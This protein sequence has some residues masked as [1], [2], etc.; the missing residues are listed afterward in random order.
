MQVF[1]SF[2]GL[3]SSLIG[4]CQDNTCLTYVRY[5]NLQLY[6]RNVDTFMEKNKRILEHNII[7][8]LFKKNPIFMFVTPNKCITPNKPIKSNLSNLNF[9]RLY[10]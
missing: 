4:D 10:S 8:A 6:S 1:K 2:Q 3:N 7:F 5:T 9:Q